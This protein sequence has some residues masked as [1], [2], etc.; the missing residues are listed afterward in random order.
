MMDLVERA[1]KRRFPMLPPEEIGMHAE[2]QFDEYLEA[3][4]QDG[5]VD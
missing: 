3:A 4:V 1:W 5:F 2:E